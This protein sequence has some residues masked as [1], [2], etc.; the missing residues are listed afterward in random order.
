VSDCFVFYEDQEVYGLGANFGPH[1]LLC[2]CV[3]DRVG[4]EARRLQSELI[5]MKPCRGVSRQVTALVQDAPAL[6][7]RR[8]AVFAVFDSDRL[9]EQLG[10]DASTDPAAVLVQRGV[11][12]AVRV[13]LL[14]RNTETLVDAVLRCEGAG[15]RMPRKKPAERDPHPQPRGRCGARG[16]GLRAEEGGYLPCDRRSCGR[17]AQRVASGCPARP[18]SDDPPAWP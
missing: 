17:R 8:T 4:I 15:G 16:P 13:L 12:P 3:G 10:V 1:R 5:H 11:P 6:L 2:A 9:H 7:A 14:Q 18:P